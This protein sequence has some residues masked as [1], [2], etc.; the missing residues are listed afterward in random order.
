MR[1]IVRAQRANQRRRQRLN[2]QA[3]R[4][5]GADQ[6]EHTVTAVLKVDLSPRDARSAER[7]THRTVQ[8]VANGQLIPVGAIPISETLNIDGYDCPVN[9]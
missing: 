5:S 2:E 4:H 9:G 3:L 1:S 7:L 8:P 6:N